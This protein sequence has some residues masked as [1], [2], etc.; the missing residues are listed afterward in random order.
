MPISPLHKPTGGSLAAIN[1]LSTSFLS[2][3]KSL[4]SASREKDDQQGALAG[5][6]SNIS[7]YGEIPPLAL[8]YFIFSSSHIVRLSACVRAT[9]AANA[10]ASVNDKQLNA[11]GPSSLSFTH[12]ALLLRVT[13]HE[14]SADHG[15]SSSGS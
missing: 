4:V 10:S 13:R 3:A 7:L 5:K 15:T 6:R 14:L 11:M 8:F 2:C 1:P 12:S 9:N